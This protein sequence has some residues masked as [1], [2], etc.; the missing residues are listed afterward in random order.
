MPAETLTIKG[1]E[2]VARTLTVDQIVG[3]LKE[4][5]AKKE[6]K[7]PGKESKPE[8]DLRLKREEIELE[9]EILRQLFEDP[10]EPR[11]FY[12]SLKCTLKDLNSLEPEDVQVLM[13]AVARANPIYAGM[14][15]RQRQR[16]AL[17]LNAALAKLSAP[18]PV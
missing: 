9:D 15:I 16:Q 3:I 18:A 10:I 7:T 14:E 2:F 5:E 8:K 6:N 11:I 17:I 4:R 12:A 13:E 1:K